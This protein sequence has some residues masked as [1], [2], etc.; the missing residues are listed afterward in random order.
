M[1]FH[2]DLWSLFINLLASAIFTFV[3]SG[4]AL[5][6]VL[7]RHQ[8]VWQFR[9]PRGATVY[10]V[11]G[12]FDSPLTA[13]G[14]RHANTAV[15]DAVALGHL[16]ASLSLAYRT[17]Y[18]LVPMASI[19]FADHHWNET[20]VLIGGR[21][22]ND[23]TRFLLQSADETFGLPLE[24]MDTQPTGARY[25]LDRRTGRR[26]EAKIDGERIVLDYG[27]IHRFPSPLRPQD[28][29]PVLLFYGLHAAGTLAVARLLSAEYSGLLRGEKRLKRQ[30]AFQVLVRARVQNEEVFP[31]IVDVYPVVLKNWPKSRP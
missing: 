9:A 20:V 13:L 5:A 24:I 27:V 15:S 16:S 19:S 21:V 17:K 4:V 1:N 8:S 22:R 6:R 14:Y 26:Y 31:E 11:V 10:L 3:V 23:A 12:T 28:P 2:S 25:I 29:N 18:R 30:R 7:G